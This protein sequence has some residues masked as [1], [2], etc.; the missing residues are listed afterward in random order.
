[1]IGLWQR[2]WR[3]WR[4]AG[5]LRERA[6][7]DPLWQLTLARFPFLGQRAAEDVTE[8]RRLAT[9]FLAEKE[10]SGMH[11]LQ[12]TDEMAVFVAAQA[13]LPV[14]KLGL[15]HYGGFV[16]IVIHPD[17]AVAR[18]ERLDEAGVLHQFEETLAGEA[19][20]GGPVMLS[21]Q[22][23]AQAGETAEWGYNVV[24]HEFAHVLDM[25]R[26]SPDAPPLW[27]D[28]ATHAA[29]VV[30]LNAEYQTLCQDVAA[31]RSTF[32]DDYGAE[33]VE[34]FFAVASE[35]FFVQPAE[36]RQ[37]CP[38]LYLLLSQYYRQD[39]AAWA[40][41]RVAPPPPAAIRFT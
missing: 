11:G 35:T 27:P 16:G 41:P 39:P 24:I 32:L 15:A 8:L 36:L 21:W 7:P 38:T 10:F 13:A 17:L 12:V 30:A 22:D 28:R 3:A 25:G 9:L 26:A 4:E 2:R 20:E 6:I 37:A 14:L 34:E 23:V 29:W 40:P 19:M 1:V 5:I 31:G 18:R 33:A